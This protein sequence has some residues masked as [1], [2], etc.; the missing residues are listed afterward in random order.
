MPT[1]Y[2]PE[3]GQLGNTILSRIADGTQIADSTAET[4]LVPDYTIPANYLAL[5]STIRGFLRGTCSNV[6]TTPGTLIYR[7]HLGPLTLSATAVVA[8][9][10]LGLDTTA[11]T[12]F[13]WEMRFEIVCRTVGVSG[14]C[15]LSGTVLQ[16]NVL[17]STAANLLP[18][19]IPVGANTAQTVNTTVANL[20]S[21]S[22]QFS[23]ATTPTNITAQD[24]VLESLA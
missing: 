2:A 17:S 23:V 5:G 11:R 20:L 18:N 21:V 1:A 12:D 6:V 16:K 14:T 15:L 10:A 22:A 19:L 13:P 3:R 8:S 4:I 9:A 7:V 24:Y